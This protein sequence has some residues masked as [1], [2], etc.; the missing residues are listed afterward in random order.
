MALGA[1]KSAVSVLKEAR[2]YMGLSAQVTGEPQQG[3]GHPVTIVMPVAV[4]G[5]EPLDS[6]IDIA[7]PRR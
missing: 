4:S 2:G 3:S 6:A 5:Q 7:L 1:I